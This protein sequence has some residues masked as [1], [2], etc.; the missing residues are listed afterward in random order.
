MDE[1]DF[2]IEGVIKSRHKPRNTLDSDSLVSFV[3]ET[4]DR[5]YDDLPRARILTEGPGSPIAEKGKEFL[6][7]LPKFAPNENWGKPGH[8]DREAVNRI[9]NAI[10]G[11]A[12]LKEKL[13][14]LAAIGKEESGITSPRRIIS[15][16]IILESL[17][18]ILT[19]FQ[20]SP[21]GFVFEAFLAA[22][23]RGAQIPASTADTIA[24]LEAFTHIPSS[25][26]A[27]A[28][29]RKGLPISLKLLAPG[30]TIEGS[31]TDLIDSLDKSGSMTY[32]IA[33][34]VGG[35]LKI[36]SFVFTRDNFLK[37]ISTMSNSGRLKS[38][39]KLF[40]RPGETGEASLEYLNSLDNWAEKYAELQKTPGYRGKAAPAKEEPDRDLALEPTGNPD[41]Q[42]VTTESQELLAESATQWNITGE[43]LDALG[44]LVHAETLAELPYAPEKLYKIAE[45]RMKALD[46]TLLDLFSATKSLSDN[47]NLYFSEEQRNNAISAGQ[48]A[49]SDTTRIA[50]NLKSGIAKDKNNP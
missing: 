36:E 35:V 15:S 5:F 6:L 18:S 37:A 42:S 39:A 11:G 46:A 29:K 43:Q 16:L 32:V 45:L 40:T 28:K 23:L 48:S 14:F 41:T 30:T 24:D 27:P 31:Y 38:T 13:D 12:T 10:G 9:F 26:N 21:A 47:V 20:P 50:E 4:L 3:E 22:L 2:L 19:S 25:G 1:L 33:R 17:S 7:T 44:K 34:K 8:A 49:I